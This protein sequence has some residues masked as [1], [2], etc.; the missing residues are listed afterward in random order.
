MLHVSPTTGRISVPLA[1][2]PQLLV[3]W[4]GEPRGPEGGE[5]HQGGVLDAD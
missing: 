4:D 3:V 2:H 5:V 1:H